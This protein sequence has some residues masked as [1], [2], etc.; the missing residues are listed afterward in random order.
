MNRIQT[1]VLIVGAGP[2]GLA[3]GIQ[4]KRL[5]VGKVLV[6]D[7]EPEAGGMP[8]FCHHW[9]FGVFDLHRWLTGPGYARHYVR[10]A[11]RHGVEIRTQTTVIALAGDRQ[12]VVSSPAGLQEIQAQ[13][14]LLATGC[15]ERPRAARLIAGDRP[16]GVFMTGSLQ[17]F[18][19]MLQGPVGKRAVLVGAELVSMSALLTLSKAHCKV[20]AIITDQPCHQVRGLYWPAKLFL[21]DLRL[22]KPILTNSVVHR[23]IGRQRVEAV[24]IRNTKTGTLRTV[25]CDTVVFT[26]DWIPDHELARRAG[27]DMNSRTQGPVVDTQLATSH[28]GLYAAGNL[29]RGAETAD[30]AAAE[31]AFAAQAMHRYLRSAMAAPQR[32]PI[33]PEAPI[34]WISPDAITLEARQTP[35]GRLCFRVQT[36]CKQA[37][38]KAMQNGE[39]LYERRYGFCVPNYSYYLSDHWLAKIKTDKSPIQISLSCGEQN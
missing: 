3:A 17:G 38:I 32:I 35:G 21:A 28:A 27:V 18:V 19:H 1:Q 26:G 9:G 10:S 8:R 37:K 31:G 36:I 5:G 39:V 25:P 14:V 20:E 2:A 13:A 7:R 23:I 12:C 11:L 30:R 15:R 29:L 34:Q 24:E 16:S 6:V 33:L 22:R 4:L